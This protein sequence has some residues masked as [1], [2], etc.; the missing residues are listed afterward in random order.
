ML[1]H[2]AVSSQKDVSAALVMTSI[3]IDVERIGDYTKNIEDLAERHP[4]RL[5]A[6]KYEATLTKLEDEVRSKFE[7]VTSA[8]KVYDIEKASGVMDEHRSITKQCDII[9]NELVTEPNT[10]MPSND[11]VALALFI[12]Y[13]KRISSHL[14]NIV[15]SVV[16][17]FEKLGFNKSDMEF[18]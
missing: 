2:L 10:E 12:R 17:P 11:L 9:V 6:G 16:N 8:F 14:T 5:N 1:T 13:L 4:K 7:A 3:V 15:S 18:D